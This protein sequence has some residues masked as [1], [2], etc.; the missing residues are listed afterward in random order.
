[1]ESSHPTPAEY[2][3]RAQ[4]RAGESGT[5]IGAAVVRSTFEHDAHVWDAIVTDGRERHYVRILGEDLGAYPPLSP[6]DVELGV[7]RFAA[8]LPA[9]H[10]LRFL[11]DANPL[12]I[13]RAGQ[14]TD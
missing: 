2:L 12:H 9:Q 11:L 13:D 7:E 3:E 14:V 6:E 1:M 4:L 10:R 8:T 5:G